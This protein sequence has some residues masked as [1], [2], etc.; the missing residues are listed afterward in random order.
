[1]PAYY[2]PQ[3]AGLTQKVKSGLIR[4]MW[5]D[6][7]RKHIWTL[8]GNAFTDIRD[9]HTDVVRLDS[10]LAVIIPEVPIIPA[11]IYLHK[12]GWQLTTDA[13]GEAQLKRSFTFDRAA[14]LAEYPEQTNKSVEE[15]VNHCY[16]GGLVRPACRIR[17]SNAQGNMVTL[18]FAAAPTVG[19]PVQTSAATIMDDHTFDVSRIKDERNVC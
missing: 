3:L 11:S 10:F 1:V 4:S 2:S 8:I 5:R 17:R 9:N 13:A 12:M 14:L 18:P 16:S 15:L 7:G 6:D 19:G